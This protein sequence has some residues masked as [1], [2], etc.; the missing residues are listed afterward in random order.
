MTPSPFPPKR[1][2][3]LSSGDEL[4]MRA[5]AERLRQSAAAPAAGAAPW[6]D[7]V[8]DAA[9]A[10]E[11]LLAAV[12]RTQDD[13]TRL[14][15]ELRRTYAALT[16]VRA[17]LVGTQAG[18]R[19]QRHDAEHDSL[20]ALPN[21]RGFSARLQDALGQ[22]HHRA[23]AL[24]VL[25]L[26]LDGFKPINDQH[27][28]AT[29]DALLQ[30]VADRLSRC[31]RAEDMVCRLGGDE[32]AC[33]LADP[34]GREQLGRI[35]STLFDAVSAPLQLGPLQLSVRPS[36]GIALCPE[37]GNTAGALLHSADAAMYR[38][39]RRQMGFAFFDRRSDA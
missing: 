27:G 6:H 30:I 26:D 16:A 38:A 28:H 13:A 9:Q 35:A 7:L 32:F 33:L 34:M 10:L 15:I 3:A 20:T 37:D 11:G 19:R 1:A 31:L 22:A 29:G 39:K 21:R 36:I 12:D 25:Y 23:P 24:A 18:E 2:P 8:L 14:Q 17:E 4:L 5:M